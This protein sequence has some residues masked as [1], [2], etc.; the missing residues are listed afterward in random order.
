M[1]LVS[2]DGGGEACVRNTPG[3]LIN[4]GVIHLAKAAITRGARSMSWL[5][6]TCVLEEKFRIRKQW[7][8]DSTDK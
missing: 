5:S 6:E 8:I 1:R 3:N 2:G 7:F 4:H